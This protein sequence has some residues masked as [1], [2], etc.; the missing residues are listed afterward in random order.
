MPVELD[1]IISSKD[2]EY[3]GCMDKSSR[4]WILEY[5]KY[6][7]NKSN[8]YLFQEICRNEERIA[9]IPHEKFL[10]LIDDLNNCFASSVA[11]LLESI[12]L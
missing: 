11:L 6:Y 1:S 9:L 7:M 5:E 10:K 8:L 3:I 4:E 2:F 12:R